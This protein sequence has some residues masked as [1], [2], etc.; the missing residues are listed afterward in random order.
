MITLRMDGEEVHLEAEEWRRWVEDGRIPP[1][2]WV[3]FPGG[4]WMRAASF[5]DY[6]ALAPTPQTPPAGGVASVREV[7]LPRHGLSAPEA[8]ILANLL[9]AGTLVLL[10]RGAYEPTIR[11]WTTS[12]WHQIGEGSAYWWWVPT[13]FL[14]AGP[15]HLFYNMIAL[16]ITSGV[17]EFLTGRFW[18]Y[19]IYLASGLVGMAVS[20]L[21][22]GNPPVSIGASGAVYGLAGAAIV[23]ILR[24]RRLFTYRQRWKTWRVYVPLF[25][26]LAL[27]SL[28]EADYWGHSG[29]LLGGLVLGLF[30]PPHRRVKDLAAP[31]D[32]ITGPE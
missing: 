21:G 28:L 11:A 8:L 6:R 9:T 20:Y 23:L 17:V 24:R 26:V 5:P 1:Q 2:A 32:P 3:L 30:V 19:A 10:L 18:T 16:A 7:L 13:L 29:G 31:M 15:R 27:P 22:H 14:H 25:L 12:W 4:S